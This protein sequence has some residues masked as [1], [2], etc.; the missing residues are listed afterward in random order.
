MGWKIRGYRLSVYLLAG[1]MVLLVLTGVVFT[2]GL[3]WYSR[4]ITVAA[5]RDFE[6]RDIERTMADLLLSM[7]LNRENALL[8]D[9]PEYRET[10]AEDERKFS[11][12]LERLQTLAVS[13]EEREV[14]QRLRDRYEKRVPPAD[15]PEKDEEPKNLRERSG[16][17]VPPEGLAPKGEEPPAQE[18]AP[19]LPLE[20]VQRLME[21]NQVQMA[22]HL[23]QM[24][25]LVKKTL[26]M[27]MV[28]AASS[29]VFAGILP[30]LLIRSITGPIRRL[31]KGTQ[32]ISAGRFSHRVE[33]SSRDELGELADAFN[34]MAHQLKKLDELKTDFIAIVSHELRTPLTSMKEAV[35]LLHEEAVGPVNPKQRSLLKITAS[36]IEKLAVFIS[37][38]LK[39]TKMEGGVEQMHQG[40]IDFHDLVREKI[41]TFQL[42]AEKKQVHLVSEFDPDPFPPVT[43]DAVRLRQVLGNLLDNAIQHSPPGGEISLRVHSRKGKTLWNRIKVDSGKT[44][45]RPW[46]YVTVSDPGQGIP[47]EEWNR[48]FDKFY[49]IRRGS[50]SPTGSGLGLS[51]AKHIVEAHAGRIWV[52]ESSENGTTLAFAIPQEGVSAAGRPGV[53]EP[54]ESVSASSQEKV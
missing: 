43:G 13:G 49:Q 14:L 18:G 54:L 23:K 21:L 12:K 22:H 26:R 40:R 42:M 30:F 35:E 31:Q 38:I 20:E 33:L 34:E 41:K 46:V 19:E 4:E 52:E 2:Y 7:E 32:E 48:V 53:A 1:L 24:D 47:R 27:G 9:K 36:G 6:A 50:N 5:N 25:L 37:D 8:L 10:Y 44:L 16:E 3:A 29:I 39:L 28:L 51:I 45:A 11:T 15:L 17:R